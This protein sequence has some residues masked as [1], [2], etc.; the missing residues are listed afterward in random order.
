M[1]EPSGND[2]EL[3][4]LQP[5]VTVTELHSEAA[6]NNQEQLVFGFV[7]MPDKWAC[8][9]DQLHLLAVELADDFGF[10]VLA[11]KRELLS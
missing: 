1:L 2:K 10:P 7:M 9:L 5:D 6:L 11:E 8:E 3:S 4:R